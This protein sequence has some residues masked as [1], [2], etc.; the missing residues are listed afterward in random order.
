MDIHSGKV[1]TQFRI[2]KK[3]INFNRIITLAF[4]H[5]NSGRTLPLFKLV[6]QNSPDNNIQQ[7]DTKSQLSKNILI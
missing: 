1:F 6:S 2:H 5:T 3:Y 4:R 7:I